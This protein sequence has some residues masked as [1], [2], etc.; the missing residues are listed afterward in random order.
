MQLKNAER[1]QYPF[2]SM[3][4]SEYRENNNLYTGTILAPVAG[5]IK[6]GILSLLEN[7]IADKYFYYFFL[8]FE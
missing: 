2:R 4:S 8:F 7:L 3:T 5:R 1:R 6:N